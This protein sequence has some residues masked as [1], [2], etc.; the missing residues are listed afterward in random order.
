MGRVYLQTSSRVWESLAV[1]NVYHRCHLCAP[2][3]GEG[4]GTS[5]VVMAGAWGDV[6][7]NTARHMCPRKGGQIWRM[8]I[9][10][11]AHSCAHTAGTPGAAHPLCPQPTY[12]L[13]DTGRV[14]GTRA[15]AQPTVATRGL[16]GCLPS[17][18]AP[19]NSE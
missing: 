10:P 14:C 15:H 7:I 17:E 16:G 13:E 4:R 11:V 19:R 2:T 9:E 8:Q 18:M 3:W 1:R 12:H 5:K 6:C